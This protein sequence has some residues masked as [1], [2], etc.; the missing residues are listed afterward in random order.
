M[1]IKEDIENWQNRLE[2]AHQDGIHYAYRIVS[3]LLNS[4]NENAKKPVGNIYELYITPI[5]KL[6]IKD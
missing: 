3:E 6:Y 1:I 4:A 2:D 5:V